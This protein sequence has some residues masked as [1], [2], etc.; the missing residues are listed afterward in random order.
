MTIEIHI[1]ELE[2]LIQEWMKSGRFQNV[3]EALMQAL[4]SSP[5]PG[6]KVTGRSG[7]KSRAMGSDLVAAMQ[8][9]PF[10]EISLEPA[11]E[12]MPVR[13]VVF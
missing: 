6:K 10:K 5:L 8:A 11:R 7:E 2:V 12:P 1:P 4:K 13:D 3:E 9:S